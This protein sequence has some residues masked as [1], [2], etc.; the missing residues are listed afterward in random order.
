MWKL[1]KRLPAHTTPSLLVRAGIS[2]TTWRPLCLSGNPHQSLLMPNQGHSFTSFA[3]CP[4]CPFTLVLQLPSG[5]LPNLPHVHQTEPL[6]TRA[7]FNS[8]QSCSSSVCSPK[9]FCTGR[10]QV[11]ERHVGGHLPKWKVPLKSSYNSSLSTQCRNSLSWYSNQTCWIMK[12]QPKGVAS[13]DVSLD[14]KAV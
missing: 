5:K 7:A 1:Y 10:M 14:S 2:L 13:Q 8:E 12:T 11:R 9:D 6:P 3:Q 4:T